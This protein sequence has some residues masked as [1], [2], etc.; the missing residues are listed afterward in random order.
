MIF[1]SDITIQKIMKVAEK[2]H[3][4]K[5]IILIGDYSPSPAILTF[6]QLMENKNPVPYPEIVFNAVN[7]SE[8][9]ALIMCSSGTTGMPKGVQLTQ[10]NVLRTLDKIL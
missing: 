4:V 8:D 6:K 5:T 7:K 1:A 2:L 9:I 3:F 10:S